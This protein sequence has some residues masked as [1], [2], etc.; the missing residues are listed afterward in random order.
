MHPGIPTISCKIGLWVLWVDRKLLWWH[1]VQEQNPQLDLLV[2]RAPRA[3]H[4]MW[5]LHV[6]LD[7]IS[8]LTINWICTLWPLCGKK[9]AVCFHLITFNIFFPGKKMTVAIFV[10]HK[11]LSCSENMAPFCHSIDI[12]HHMMGSLRLRICKCYSHISV[13]IDILLFIGK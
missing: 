8:W 4:R 9:N 3:I 12:K 5:L 1:G 13:I 6:N 2:W 7:S 11:L 10:Y